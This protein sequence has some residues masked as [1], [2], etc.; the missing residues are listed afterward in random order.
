MYNNLSKYSSQADEMAAERLSLLSKTIHDLVEDQ[1]HPSVTCDIWSSGSQHSYISFTVHWISAEFE[2][3]Y[4]SLG[5]V[6]YTHF[7]HSSDVI[8]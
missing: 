7:S 6:P 4:E 1:L 2:S 3:K 8:A 5:T